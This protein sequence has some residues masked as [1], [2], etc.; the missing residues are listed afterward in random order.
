MN[1]KSYSGIIFTIT[2]VPAVV[3]FIIGCTIWYYHRKIECL[4]LVIMKGIVTSRNI[5]RRP[6]YLVCNRKLPSDNRYQFFFKSLFIIAISVQCFFLFATVDVTYQCIDNPDVD[7]FKKKDDVKL[8]DTF[9]Y[10]ESP[11]N[12]SSI[13]KD[14]FV[15]CYRITFFDPDGALRGAAAAYLLFKM[16]NFGFLLVSYT[17][18]WVA[19]KLE[20]RGTAGTF[21]WFKLGFCLILL[22]VLFIPLILRVNVDTIESTVRKLSYTVFVQAIS[23]ALFVM[24]SVAFIPW[25][26]FIK[27]EEYYVDASLPDQ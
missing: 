5:D 3:I 4:M 24:Y 22:S 1:L 14:D 16:L 21:L 23:V 15:I 20:E 9:A 6:T 2:F 13:S 27:S 12:C 18:L 26:E 7:C 19:Q 17:M 8:S 11:V 10:D 25:E